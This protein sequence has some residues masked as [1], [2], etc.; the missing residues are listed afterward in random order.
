V[1]WKGVAIEQG[2]YADDWLLEADVVV[3]PAYVEHSPRA[4][5]MAVAAGVPVIATP[6]C[7]VQGLPG[8]RLV[9]PGDADSLRQ[10]LSGVLADDRSATVQRAAKLFGGAV[11]MP[12]ASVRHPSLP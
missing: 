4:L 5:L 3:L 2:N 8:I 9:P 12:F 10:V 7:G 6:A 11:N 1:Q